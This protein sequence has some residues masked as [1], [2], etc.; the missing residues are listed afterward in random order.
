MIRGIFVRL[1]LDLFFCMELSDEQRMKEK[2][3]K[4]SALD[5]V[6]MKDVLNNGKG[7]RNGKWVHRGSLQVVLMMRESRSI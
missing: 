2:K 5:A 4:S 3:L 1:Q 7:I 6:P